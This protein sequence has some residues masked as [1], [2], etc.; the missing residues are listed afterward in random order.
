MPMK[1]YLAVLA[2]VLAACS[3]GG[4]TAATPTAPTTTE[5]TTMQLTSPAF[6]EGETIPARYTCDAEEVSPPLRITNVPQ[7]AAALIA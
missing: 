2:T 3:G 5:G 6:S 1:R 7:G 4:T